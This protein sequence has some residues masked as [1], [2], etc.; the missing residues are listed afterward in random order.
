MPPRLGGS[1]NLASHNCAPLLHSRERNRSLRKQHT[2]SAASQRRRGASGVRRLRRL[3][4]L[5]RPRERNR[6]LRELRIFVLPVLSSKLDGLVKQ[7]SAGFFP[8]DFIAVEAGFE[9]AVG[10][11]TQHFE[12]CTFGRSDTPP[13]RVFSPTKSIK[14]V[15]GK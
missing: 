11:P 10:C 2:A 6:S 3:S 5:P 14:D 7:K 1:S 9:P 13:Y 8:S 15:K 12:C 4:P